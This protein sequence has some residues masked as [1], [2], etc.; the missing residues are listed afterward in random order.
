MDWQPIETAPKDN[1]RLLYLARFNPDTGALEGIDWDGEWA[2][3]S[4][5][6]EMPQVYWYWSSAHATV[7]EPTHWAYQEGPPPMTNP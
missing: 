3:D 6:W 4:E 7:E 1:K 2:S 5:S